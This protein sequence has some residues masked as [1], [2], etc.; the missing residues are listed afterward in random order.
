MS[1]QYYD[2]QPHF[3]IQPPG[4]TWA[5]QRIILFNALVFTGQLLIDIP[6]SYYLDAPLNMFQ[7]FYPWSGMPGG[8]L[9]NNVLGYQSD[10]FLRLQLWKPLTYQFIHG[11]LSHLFFNMLLL[12]FFGPGLERVLGTAQFFKF[13]VACGCVAVLANLIPDLLAFGTGLGVPSVA[14][15]SGAVMGVVVAYIALDLDRTFYLFPLPIP[16][17][18]RALLLILVVINVLYGLMGSNVS[19]PTHFGGM[20][21]GF[22]YMR[23]R[24]RVGRWWRARKIQA[25]PRRS[26]RKEKQLDKMGKAVDNIFNFDDK[27]RS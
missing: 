4:I 16:L 27:D 21:F 2:E 5:V 6:S 3:R 25:K 23:Y 19:V 9:I 12:L 18:G 10:L 26:S 24:P 11:G 13:Y 22:A 20:A 1:N 15:A 7:G 17:N 14:G 8:T